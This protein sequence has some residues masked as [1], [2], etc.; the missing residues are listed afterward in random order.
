MTS[1][2]GLLV[3]LPRRF[4]GPGGACV[5]LRDGAVVE[6]RAWGWA[7][8]ERRIPFTPKTLFRICSIT[9]QFTCALALDTSPNLGDLDDAVASRLPDLETSPR[10]THLCNNQSGLRDYWAV[11]MLHGSPAEARFADREA[12][13][14]I[15]GTRSLQFSPGSRYSY[16]NQNFRI[17]SDV[18][19]THTDRPFAELLRSRIFDRFG[20]AGALLAADTAALPDGTQGYEGSQTLGFKPARNRVIWTGDAGIAASLEDMI[21]WERSIDATRH[22]PASLYHRLAAPVAFADGTPAQYGFG[23]GRHSMFGRAT[24]GHGGA[25][26]GWRSHR[27]HVASERVSVVVLFNHMADAQQAAYL[28]LAATLGETVEPAAEPRPMPAFAGSYLEPET[29]LAVRIQPGPPGK[30]L[31]HYDRFPEALTIN[32]DGSAGHTDSVRLRSEGDV[33]WMDRAAD[34]QSTRLIPLAADARGDVAGRYRCA[35]LDAELVIEDA[36][37]TLYGAFSGFLGSGRME[38]LDPVAC[39]VW[40]LP[41]PRALDHTPPGNWTLAVERDGSDRPIA[42]SV[43][44]WLARG[45]RYQRVG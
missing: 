36:G 41:C 27:L 14:I 39:D 23:L 33:V 22:D 31:L 6:Q 30:V 40:T 24:T 18:L 3:E 10:T 37:G 26:R 21:A 35:E 19:E 12:A 5:V 38:L 17:L 16:A 25:L 32:A 20:M 4:P 1:L 2:D 45:L 44:C 28:L 15:G 42:I 34:H 11:A 13:R 7:D 9:K 29:S 43:G 8:A